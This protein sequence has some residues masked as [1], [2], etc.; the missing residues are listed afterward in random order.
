MKQEV[1][2]FDL[3]VKCD[4]VTFA[5]RCI[6]TNLMGVGADDKDS[7]RLDKVFVP[8]SHNHVCL[9]VDN[10]SLALLFDNLRD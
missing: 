2:K 9:C 8:W 7:D 5:D 6:E 1:H 10:F 4:I 3:G